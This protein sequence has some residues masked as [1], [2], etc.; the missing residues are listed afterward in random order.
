M[1][2]FSRYLATAAL[3]FTS[4]AQTAP[5]RSL[6]VRI[7]ST[8]LAG[9]GGIGEWGFAAVVEIDG[10]RILFDTGAR[11]R[12]VLENARELKVDLASITDVILTHNHSD[13]TGGLV[14][15]R[16]ELA[17]QNP[18]AVSRAYAASGMFYSRGGPDGSEGNPMIAIRRDYEAAGGAFVESSKP[19]RIAPG[20]WLTGPVPRPNPERNWSGGGFLRRPG[21]ERAEDNLPEDQSLVLDTTRGLVLISGCGHAGII[22]TVE[23]ARATVREAPVYAAIG[24]FHLFNASDEHLAWTAEKLKS[25]G[26]RHFWG[27]HCTGIETVYR[28]RQ[29]AGLGRRESVVGA[30]G[31]TFRLDRGIEA[32]AIAR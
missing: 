32:G 30:V 29:L 8:M 17:R 9:Q 21:G 24:G 10:R 26:L 2:Q 11:P 3:T 15:L 22:N 18:K 31:A 23:H 4:F 28:M 19:V 12:T 27:A 1:T 14:T 25:F 20:A 5:I 7:L 13:H 16:R 6:E